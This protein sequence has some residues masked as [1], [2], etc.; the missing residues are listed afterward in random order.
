M[1]TGLQGLASSGNYGADILTVLTGSQCGRILSE[2]ARLENFP[3]RLDG[4][5][6]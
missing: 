4:A 6:E 2:S 3:V 1:D 5:Q